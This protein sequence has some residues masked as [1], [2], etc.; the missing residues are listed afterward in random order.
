MKFLVRLLKIRKRKHFGTDGIRGSISKET[1]PEFV[2]KLG[3]A[4]GKVFKEQGIKALIIGK[5]TRISGYMLE[6]ALQ[7]GIISAGVDVRLVGPMPTPAVSYLAS[8]FKNQAGVVI[9]ASHNSYEDNGIKFFGDDGKK[10]SN[11][12]EEKIEKKLTEELDVSEA[13]NLGKAARLSDAS[14]RYIEFCK[15]SL[16]RN[17]NFNKL[18][19]VLDVANGATYD[20]A[21]KVF[22]ELGADIIVL[23]NTPD[24]T[25]INKD[26]GSTNIKFLQKEV[27]KNKADFGIA[28]DGDG[29]RLIIVDKK[30]KELN[31]DDILFVLA[32]D[33]FENQITLGSKGIV[34]TIMTNKG[35][36]N[37]L[38][39][40]GVE[41]VRSDVGDRY[42]LQKL[43]ELNWDL[44]GE[45]SGHIISLDSSNS[46]DAIIAAIK[47]LEAYICSGLSLDQLLKPFIKYPQILTNV[48]TKNSE[49]VLKN[50][51]FQNLL[52]DI[53]LSLK[54]YDGRV[55]VR[56]SGTEPLIRI[57]VESKNEKETKSASKILSNFVKKLT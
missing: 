24:G 44:G 30:A 46:G 31:G 40:M 48:K 10:I 11:D 51:N 47:F 16:K 36:E 33:Q 1:N 42:V 28:F 43:E 4:A 9:S 52:R 14:G 37:S 38:L 27:L 21:P 45:Q 56:P 54:K 12:L 55:N 3:W 49:K 18:K 20:V 7:S 2:L 25:N 23:S 29:D 15:N 34:G 32:R 26:C 8:S 19:I 5:D 13:K 39:K 41:L 6:T 35:L 53:S 22:K 50:K 57:M 17:I